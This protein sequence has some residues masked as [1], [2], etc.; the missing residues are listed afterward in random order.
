MSP[1]KIFFFYYF[2]LNPLKLKSL[3]IPLRDIKHNNFNEVNNVIFLL[4]I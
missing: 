2:N 3:G 4:L 1:L